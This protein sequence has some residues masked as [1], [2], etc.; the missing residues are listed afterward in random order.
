[1]CRGL[2][3]LCFR[4]G[5]CDCCWCPPVASPRLPLLLVNTQK[6]SQVSSRST[7][8][9]LEYRAWSNVARVAGAADRSPRAFSPACDHRPRF[10]SDTFEIEPRFI[11]KSGMHFTPSV[12]SF[13]RRSWGVRAAVAAS[14]AV[15]PAHE[16]LQL[17]INLVPRL[18]NGLP[19]TRAAALL[20]L[21][22]GVDDGCPAA[23][24][25]VR[26]S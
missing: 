1:M 7:S 14:L 2:T 5:D 23:R 26:S 13:S 20:A 18:R 11:R 24:G 6:V 15:L 8:V 9:C 19:C 10:Q 22:T 12:P 17:P 25:D 3:R 4:T 21:A 16:T